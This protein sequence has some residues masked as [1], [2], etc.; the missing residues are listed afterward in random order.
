MIRFQADADLRHS[1]LLGTIRREPMIDFQGAAEAGILGL[2]DPR[3]LQLA[4][5]Q[6]R[7]LV[8][9][10][11]RTMPHH[12][13]DWLQHSESPGVLIVPQF[14]ST[15]AAIE[16]LVLIWSATEATDWINR[17]CRLPL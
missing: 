11:A 9:H 1:I 4:A 16:E 3:V 13:A 17:I 15:A 8:S 12:F 6:G 7:V 10:D 14:L 5:S 2:P